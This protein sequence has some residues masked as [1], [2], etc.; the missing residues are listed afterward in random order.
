MTAANGL[1]KKEQK[2]VIE[3]SAQ[4]SD[5]PSLLDFVSKTAL[6]TYASSQKLQD[7]GKNYQ[8]KSPYPNNN[9]LAGRLKLCIN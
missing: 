6:N 4:T 1:D 2:R 8:P 9:A 5:K 7:I 3:S